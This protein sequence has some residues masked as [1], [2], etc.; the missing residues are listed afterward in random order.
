MS[1][2]LPPV[3]EAVE[4][5]YFSISKCYWSWSELLFKLSKRSF[6]APT[7][8]SLLTAFLYILPFS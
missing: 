1:E 5:P 8:S 7:L 3:S 6:R 2:W 4:L